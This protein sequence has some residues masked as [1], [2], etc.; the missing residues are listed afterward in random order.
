MD[1]IFFGHLYDRYDLGWPVVPRIGVGDGHGCI[2][3]ILGFGGD[4]WPAGWGYGHGS[5]EPARV[6]SCIA[7]NGGCF[8]SG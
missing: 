4:G 1:G 2:R 6:A 3:R 5:V 8:C 7:G